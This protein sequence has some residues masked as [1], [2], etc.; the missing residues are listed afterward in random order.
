MF[1]QLNP[2]TW[3]EADWRDAQLEPGSGWY[4]H[5]ASWAV[6]TEH[7][8]ATLVG[9][10]VVDVGGSAAD[11]FVACCAVEQVV[12]P[13]TTSLGGLIGGLFY[14]AATGQIVAVNAGL[15]LP[16]DWDGSYRHERDRETGAAVLVPGA[17]AGLDAFWRRWGRLPWKVLWQPAIHFAR[18]GFP[19]YGMYREN[20][21]RRWDVLNSQPAGRAAF[22]RPPNNGD[23]YRLPIL[24][25]TLEAIAYEGVRYCY[26]GDWAHQ[27]VRE[28]AKCGG[29]ISESDLADYEARFAPPVT[30]RYRGHDFCTT[31]PPQ[32]GG[33]SVLGAAKVL[34]ELAGNRR[35]SG[36]VLF[37]QIQAVNEAPFENIL[38][39][40]SRPPVDANERLAHAISDTRAHDEAER[41]RRT[42]HGGSSPSVATP[43]SHHLAIVDRDGNA[44]TATFTI[45]A[46][47]W[48]DTGIVV[49]GIAL[50]SGAYQTMT[51]DPGPGGRIA[52]P[53]APIIILENGE[54]RMACGAI[55]TGLIACQAQIL[56]DTIGTSES[57]IDAVARPRFGGVE[58][59]LTAM[60][61]RTRVVVEDLPIAVLDEAESY[62]QPISRTAEPALGHA[63]ADVGYF[64]AI[65]QDETGAL[66]AITD[67]RLTGRASAG[68]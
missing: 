55:G 7:P 51:W 28:V 33:I 68:N 49:G 10:K 56:A 21:L 34:D 59:D 47:S 27:L 11:A 22:T 15:Q 57:I 54:L 40:A 32:F 60:Q 18:H 43:H 58:T 42:A 66:T 64:T 41:I 8:L 36:R 67:P 65:A 63:T 30:A 48:G 16:S 23:L 20:M 38:F 45:L 46:D 3:S 2:A 37:E 24:A 25:D 26:V 35:E 14:E 12:M 53:I 17:V 29:I 50:N 4:A 39:D 13:G 61:E 5:G 62:G 44:L 19:M 9:R 6:S 31:P 1:E 52:E